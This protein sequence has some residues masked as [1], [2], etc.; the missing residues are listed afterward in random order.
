MSLYNIDNRLLFFFPER[1]RD[2]TSSTRSFLSR[3]VM[4]HGS[5][6]PIHSSDPER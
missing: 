2:M 1:V 4:R 6:P 5:Y 3:R